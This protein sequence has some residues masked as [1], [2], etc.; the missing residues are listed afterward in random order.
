[1]S[2]NHKDGA[3]TRIGGQDPVVLSTEVH[4]CKQM[5]Y[6][7]YHHK[8]IYHLRS[9]LLYHFSECEDPS[10]SR[11]AYAGSAVVCTLV[12]R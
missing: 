7:G 3:T 11:K 2:M 6:R 8:I 4:H 9:F 10:C 12:S 1:M 5:G